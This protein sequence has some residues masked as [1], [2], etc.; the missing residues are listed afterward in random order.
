M[1]PSLFAAAGIGFILGLRHACEPDHLAAVST[2]ATRQGGGGGGGAGEGSGGGKRSRLGDGVRLGMAWGIGHTLTVGFVATGVVALGLR[3]PASLS[4]AAELFVALLLVLLGLPVVLRYLLGRWHMHLHT[5]DGAAH[6]HLH[7]HAYGASHAHTHS[8]A[9]GGDRRRALGLGLAHGLAGSA[10][11]VVLLVAAAP[12]AVLRVAYFAAFGAG[13][14]IGMATVSLALAAFVRLAS[15]RGTR[16]ATA[17]H[18]GSAAASVALG[19]MLAGKVLGG[20]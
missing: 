13:T 4:S 8:V 19:L 7:S 17:L 16:W 11:I 5:H 10:A 14:I 20:S 6:V 1:V 9:G 2:L 12:T 15:H 3:F 18:V